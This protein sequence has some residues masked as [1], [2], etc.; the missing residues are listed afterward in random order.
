MS[1]ILNE[2]DLAEAA[3]FNAAAAAVA[4]EI[5]AGL[6]GVPVAG[7]VATSPVA[8]DGIA[9]SPVVAPVTPAAAA[10]DQSVALVTKL[11]ERLA[12]LEQQ[13]SAA[14][15][16]AAP[17]TRQPTLTT[18]P[19]LDPHGALRTLGIDPEAFERAVVAKVLGDQAPVEMRAQVAATGQV[20]SLANLVKQQ[21]LD[22][23]SLRRE[24]GQ[25]TYQT[26]LDQ[27][28]NN[29]SADDQPELA[30]VAKSKRDWLRGAALDIVRQDAV[31]RRNEPNAAPLPPSDAIKRLAEKLSPIFEVLRARTA[32]VA[33]AVTQTA[34]ATALPPTGASLGGAPPV[35]APS[36]FE[37]ATDAILQDVLRK[38]NIK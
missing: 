4:A 12:G 18:D 9:S 38:Y 37:E 8:A 22:I 21:A 7:M 11:M 5:T 33:P 17:E 31:A 32:A 15:K 26:D 3:Q 34:T 27:Y 13:L 20:Q 28:I 30:E 35:K 24:L 10:P 29:I 1:A 23:A 6:D 14:T 36:S 16:P 2:Q 25:T 19:Y